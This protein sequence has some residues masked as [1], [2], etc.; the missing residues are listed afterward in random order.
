MFNKEIIVTKYVF[1]D[2]GKDIAFAIDEQKNFNLR[3]CDAHI[4]GNS[5]ILTPDKYSGMNQ[6]KLEYLKPDWIEKLKSHLKITIAE[7]LPNKEFGDIVEIR[8]EK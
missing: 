1:M 8:L 7:C 4:E 6:L 5:V 3:L 2:N